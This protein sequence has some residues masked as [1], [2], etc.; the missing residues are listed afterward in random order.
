MRNCSKYYNSFNGLSMGGTYYIECKA[1]GVREHYS[2]DYD[3]DFRHQ[4]IAVTF[5]PIET[6]EN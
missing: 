4:I 3:Y 6:K 1:W 5:F 2:A